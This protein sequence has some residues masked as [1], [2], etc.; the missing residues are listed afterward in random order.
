M[1]PICLFLLFY[2][3]HF[4][5]VLL[6]VRCSGAVFS[7]VIVFFLLFVSFLF[8]HTTRNSFSKKFC[9][10]TDRKRNKRDIK[11]KLRSLSSLNRAET[12]DCFIS[13]KVMPFDRLP[14]WKETIRLAIKTRIIGRQKTLIY[15]AYNVIGFLW[16]DFCVFSMPCH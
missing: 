13:I 15:S 9:D 3:V 1:L 5:S 16:N 8:V 14:S 12:V 6:V 7:V 10:W 11:E 2:F 4:R